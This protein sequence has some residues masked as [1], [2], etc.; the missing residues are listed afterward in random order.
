MVKSATLSGRIREDVLGQPIDVLNWSQTISWIFDWAHR[1][2]SRTVCVCD[3]H[4]VVL[5]RRN[6][7]HA[8]TI[9]SADMVTP[10]GAPVAWMLR[11]KGHR[12]QQRINGPDLMLA[13][14]RKAAETG[15]KCSSMAPPRVPCGI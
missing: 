13:C 14:C 12:D 10:D 7:A 15:P 9:F 11:R 2:E 8:D 6:S 1:R 4:S 5:A 3:V